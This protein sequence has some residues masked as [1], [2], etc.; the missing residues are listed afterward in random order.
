MKQRS[1][2]FVWVLN[3]ADNVG[4]V[5]GNDAPNNTRCL[6]RGAK[7]GEIRLRCAIPHGHKV[8]LRTIERGAPVMKYGVAIGRATEDIAPGKL[9][10]VQNMESLRGRGDLIATNGSPLAHA[11]TPVVGAQE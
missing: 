5:V 3:P 10:H 8:A 9:V 11:K 6:L 7:V 4:S 1:G 2:A